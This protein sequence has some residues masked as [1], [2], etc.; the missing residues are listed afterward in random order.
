V[1]GR[2]TV[3]IVSPPL[4]VTPGELDEGFEILDAALERLEK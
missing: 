1:Y 3:P 2:Y 4:T